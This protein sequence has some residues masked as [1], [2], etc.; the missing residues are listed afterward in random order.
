MKLFFVLER[1]GDANETGLPEQNRD[2]FVTIEDLSSRK[3]NPALSLPAN[4]KNKSR[5]RIKSDTEICTDITKLGKH[6][7]KKP[8]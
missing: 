3:Q 2:E 4:S 8:L 7:I 6:V 5:K 1:L